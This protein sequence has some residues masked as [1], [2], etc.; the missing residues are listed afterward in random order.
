MSD[1]EQGTQNDDGSEQAD[2]MAALFVVLLVVSGMIYW[3][4]QQ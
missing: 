4:S 1:L 2:A 3:V